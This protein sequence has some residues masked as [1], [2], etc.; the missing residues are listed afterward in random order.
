[1]GGK[2]FN[3]PRM[4][5]SDYLEREAEV[6]GYLDRK[7]P[8]QY[9]IPR[10]YGDKPDFGD[11]D[12]I[13]TSRPGWGELR[14][15]IARDLGITETRA[16]GHVFSTV[17]RGHQSDCVPVCD[18][19][20]DSTYS[21]MCFNDLGNFIGRI[22]RRFDLK[23]GERGLVYVFRRAGGNYTIEIEITRDFE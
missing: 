15:E 9:R 5:K 10:Y 1:M 6:R 8:G 23:Y 20:L 21:Y 22:C 7:L 11:M 19:Y 16:V 4:P 17:Y 13:L 18:R 2:L 3:L 14:A 12:V